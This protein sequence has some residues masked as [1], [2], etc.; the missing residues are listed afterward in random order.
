MTTSTLSSPLISLHRR[1][2]R[3]TLG[4]RAKTYQVHVCMREDLRLSF[5]LL[6]APYRFSSQCLF[7]WS[8]YSL[9]PRYND[10]AG[11]INL[12][13]GV[14]VTRAKW[15]GREALFTTLEILSQIK[16]IPPRRSAQKSI[17][18]G[19]EDEKKSE[20]ISSV[21]HRFA[22]PNIFPCAI[23]HPTTNKSTKTSAV[24]FSEGNKGIMSDL[25]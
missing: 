14:E 4:F 2:D 18:S 16:L 5:I 10:E 8:H 13:R 6:Q 12:H 19:V 24:V 3:V 1:I 7:M 20:S 11:E 15:E 25:R 22:F 9:S 21:A 23:I 17:S